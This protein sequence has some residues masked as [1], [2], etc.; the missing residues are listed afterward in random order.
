GQRLDSE[1]HPRAARR[2][3]RRVARRADVRQVRAEPGGRRDLGQGRAG[4]GHEPRVERLQ[5]RQRG[6]ARLRGGRLLR[7]AQHGARRPAPD[8]DREDAVAGPGRPD[9]HRGGHEHRQRG[10]GRPA[11][12]AGARRRGAD[13]ERHEAGARDAADGGA[14]PA[15]ARRAR[16]LQHPH[17]HR[18]GG[19]QRRPVAHQLL[20]PAAAARAA[21][22]R[23]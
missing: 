22:P 14:H 21:A 10:A 5:R 18:A 16:Q 11:G 4:Q 19:G 23:L 7:R 20:A 6:R 1:H 8:L 17:R 12:Q 13:R 3:P 2:G 15:L 9:A